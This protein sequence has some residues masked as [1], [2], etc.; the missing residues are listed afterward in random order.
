MKGSRQGK[1]TKP[2]WNL[3][4]RQAG[5]SMHHALA[6]ISMACWPFFCSPYSPAH[7]PGA[8]SLVVWLQVMTVKQRY[9]I[10]LGKLQTTEESV[11][12]MKQEL[13]ELQPQL[14]EAAKE[15]EAAM[16]VITRESA[17]ADKVKQVSKGRRER[18][19]QGCVWLAW[20]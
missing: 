19:G 16:E 15:T 6:S 12:V 10:G 13:I 14:A 11:N 5:H 18:G 2:R 1:Q 4:G 9:E 17:E 3:C 8:P 20:P 7:T